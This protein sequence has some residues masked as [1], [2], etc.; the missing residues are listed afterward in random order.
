ML[1]RTLRNDPTQGL[2]CKA[3]SRINE[4]VLL[5]KSIGWRTVLNFR[6]SDHAVFKNKVIGEVIKGFSELFVLT[7]KYY[8]FMAT[9]DSLFL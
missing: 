8:L 7:K 1:L 2:T 3:Q 9:I 4:L 5:S 6:L